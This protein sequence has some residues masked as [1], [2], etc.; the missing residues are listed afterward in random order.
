M[1]GPVGGGASECWGL[2]YQ[3]FIAISCSFFGIV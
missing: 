3:Y 2:L 1:G